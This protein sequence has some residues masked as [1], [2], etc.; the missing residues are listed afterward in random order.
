MKLIPVDEQIR[1]KRLLFCDDSIVS[2]TQLRD[3][4]GWLYR[5]GAKEVHMR[6]ACPPLVFGCRFLN[7]SRSRSELDLAARRAI[8]KLE[9]GEVS[10]EVLK[11]YLTY[12]SEKYERMVEE[13][14]RELN[15]TTLKF[16]KLE[17]LIKAIGVAPEKVC[18]YC[19][20][21]RDVENEAPE[22]E[23]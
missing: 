1:G 9:G 18:T 23:V 20:N 17:S 5:R 4:V 8:W 2:G 22:F 13:I 6:S 15:L 12:G 11:E 10:C 21:G 19:W 3:T 14:R 7:F 16:Q